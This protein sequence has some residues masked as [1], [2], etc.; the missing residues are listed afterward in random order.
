MG[1]DLDDA[2]RNLGEK[3]VISS[4]MIGKSNCWLLLELV[5]R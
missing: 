3:S 1:I 2:K 5:H 4:I